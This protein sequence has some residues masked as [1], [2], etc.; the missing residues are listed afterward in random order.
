MEPKL[1]KCL[2][3]LLILL[4]GIINIGVIVTTATIILD[5]NKLVKE[6]LIEIILVALITALFNYALLAVYRDE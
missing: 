2:L 6:Q 4:F 1:E 5:F 3:I